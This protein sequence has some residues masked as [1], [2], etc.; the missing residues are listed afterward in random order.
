MAAGATGHSGKY[1]LVTISTSLS[2]LAFLSAVS[3]EGSKTLFVTPLSAD[4][5]ECYTF[6]ANGSQSLWRLPTYTGS[7]RILHVDLRN[8]NLFRAQRETLPDGIGRLLPLLDRR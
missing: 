5:R 8:P 4:C 3:L 7:A 6:F 2:Q 1:G